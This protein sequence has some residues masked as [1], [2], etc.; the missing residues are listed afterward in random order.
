MS[1]TAGALVC[2]NS[3]GK[4]FTQSSFFDTL[5]TGSQRG[6]NVQSPTATAPPAISAVKLWTEAA[7]YLAQVPTLTDGTNLIGTTQGLVTSV[8]GFTLNGETA[9]AQY[10]VFKVSGPNGLPYIHFPAVSGVDLLTNLAVSAFPISLTNFSLWF[11]LRVYAYPP[12]DVTT[13][14]GGWYDAVSTGDYFA[15]GLIATGNHV[16]VCD[17]NQVVGGGETISYAD[18]PLPQPYPTGFFLFVVD[19]R[20]NTV[21]LRINGQAMQVQVGPA[22]QTLASMLST[23][24][25]KFGNLLQPGYVDV[26]AAGLADSTMTTGQRNA[27]ETYLLNR[28]ALP[29]PGQTLLAGPTTVQAQSLVVTGPGRYGGQAPLLTSGAQGTLN[30]ASTWTDPAILSVCGPFRADG[31]YLESHVFTSFQPTGDNV[32]AV[33]ETSGAGYSAFTFITPGNPSTAFGQTAFPS[34]LSVGW[35]PANAAPWGEPTTGSGMIEVAAGYPLTTVGSLRITQTNLGGGTQGRLLRS[36][37]RSNEA[38]EDYDATYPQPGDVGATVTFTVSGGA[39]NAVTAT[40]AAGGSGYPAS[41]T[42]W[43]QVTGGGG[44]GGIVLATTNSSGVVTSFATTPVAGGAG[45]TGTTG[46]TTSATPQ[47]NYPSPGLVCQ[48]G[49]PVTSVAN[50]GTLDTLILTAGA[51]V[52]VVK[53]VTNSK[54]AMYPIAFGA[55]KTA[56]FADTEFSTSQGTSSKVN[57]YV[58]NGQIRIENKTGSAALLTAAYYGA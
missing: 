8:G 15:P 29:G 14:W 56:L 48:R 17:I 27:L 22:Y 47:T 18:L 57:V 40:P 36:A 26:A 3:D 10:P 1:K 42:F 16:P 53:D 4:T 43:M 33:W 7:D 52:L 35:T 32:A 45:Y 41:S 12:N 54:A 24:C 37:W 31:G 9:S 49:T 28:Y 50:N 5:A 34:A 6:V 44:T 58:L 25:F 20:G 11:V 55:I 23:T 21:N 2:V 39:I 13:Q 19:V 38:I 51:G 30:A 46:A